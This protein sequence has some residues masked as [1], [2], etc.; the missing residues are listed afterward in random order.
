[1]MNESIRSETHLPVCNYA[2]GE[3]LSRTLTATPAVSTTIYDR[4]WEST[5]MLVH[6]LESFTDSLVVTDGGRPVGFIGSKEI[7]SG[8]LQNPTY[9]FFNNTLVGKIKNDG[10][11]IITP[12]TK[13]SDLIK[14]W[15]QTG[16]AFSIISNQYG[17]YSVISARKLLEVGVSCNTDIKV[18]DMPKKRIVSFKQNQTV[19]E[20]I[21]SMFENKT[22][23][24]ILEN[25]SQFLSDR[26]IIEKI[27]TDLKYLQDIDNF[28]DMKA[29]IF[30]LENAK[31]ITADTKVPELCKI[32]YGMLHPYV[33]TKDQVIS[34]WDLVL[35]LESKELTSYDWQK[36]T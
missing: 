25:T 31:M 33:M 13:L 22:R 4:I 2:L 11:V 12:E 16:R 18:G 34:P 21:D 29:S 7:L 6:H 36:F 3:L 28:L 9:D 30:K 10:L 35:I 27:A 5:G 32:M 8:T 14:E 20:V 1:M 19:K 17:G 26:I 15:R 23:R 24:L